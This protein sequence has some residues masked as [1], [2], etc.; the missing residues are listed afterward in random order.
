MFKVLR[1][2]RLLLVRNRF[3]DELNEEMEIHRAATEQAFMDEGMTQEAA[4]YAARQ[5]FGNT[6]RLQEQ[7]NEIVG[8]RIETV[9]QDLRFALRQLRKNPGF[10]AT[11]VLI[12]ALGIAASVSIFAFVD[13]ALIKPL[14]YRNPSR[15]V[16]LFERNTLG[17]RFHLSYLDYLD[18]MRLNRVFSSMD[19]YE[20]NGHILT[21]PTG[22]Q[23]VDAADVSDGFFRTL[24]VVP[25]LGRDFHSGED[26]PSASRTVLLSYAAWRKR[27]GGRQDILG[28]TVTLDGA[29][30]TIIGVLP[31]DFHFAPAE[32]AEFWTTIHTDDQCAKHRDCHNYFG[33]ARLND[34]VPVSSALADVTT[35]ALQLEKQYPDLNTDRHAYLLPL[36]DVIVGNIRPILLVL[37]GGAV[38]L[39]LIATVNVSSLLLMRSESR[40]REMAVRG[41]LG[42]SRL[43][44]IRQLLT[45]GLVLA[46][47]GSVLGLASAYGAMRLL[48]RLI[49]KDMMAGMPYLQD[50]GLNLHV[51]IF[52][53]VISI[54]AGVLFSL[55]PTLRLPLAE[56]ARGL[57]EGGRGAAGTTW[58]RFGS[59]LVVIELAA[60]MV[61]LVS[62]GLLGKSFYRL[63][64]VDTGIEPDHVAAIGVVTPTSAY[65]KDALRIALERQILHRAESLPGVK[66]VGIASDLPVGDGDGTTTFRILGRPYHGETNEVNDRSVSAGY[67]KTLQ[68]R[69]LRGRYFAETDDASK[70][71]VAIVNEALARKYFPGQNPIGQRIGNDQLSP[72]SLKQIIGVVD[73]IKEGPLEMT[74]RPGFYL[75]FEQNTE[76]SFFVVVRTMQAEQSLLPTLAAAIH[77]IDPGVATFGA[78]TMGVRIHDSSSAYLH[79]SSAWLVGGFAVLALLLG[80]V[81]LYGVIAYSV[82]QRTREIGVRMA[83]GAQRSSV[84]QLILKEAGWLIA[85][86][87]LTG[88]LCSIAATGLTRKLLF[89]V[90]PWDWTTL[91]GV[92]TVLGAAAMLASYLPARRA[93]SVN[94]VD[95]LRAE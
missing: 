87:I 69:L 45:E 91:A 93:A 16:T 68:A 36:A 60:A 63:L 7:S 59:G 47:G 73:D 28:H 56:M 75:P 71:Q 50:I 82:G 29:P 20:A 41:A 44:L 89:G 23:R 10:A 12:L 67:F 79:R 30:H 11:A 43:R 18:W 42:A 49:P 54:A 57:N 76:D 19:L 74:A 2:L 13:A 95:A 83:L 14:P 94:P 62:A 78:T 32:P 35:I 27:F 8:F 25:L 9:L 34:G 48:T 5:Q 66:S 53:C 38:L 80:A 17:P 65:A 26:L 39:L 22:G 31:R 88:L 1:K 3:R 46:G 55:M 84:Y 72:G 61:L 51:V 85:F 37:L 4:R 52:A 40:R 58:R 90:Q 15:L 70:P 24:G 21:T 33:L 6:T 81:G 92:A 77:G 64:H 86:G